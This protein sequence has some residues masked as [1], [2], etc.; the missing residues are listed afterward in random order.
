[1]CMK[2]EIEGFSVHGGEM[3]GSIAF[4]DRTLEE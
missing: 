3:R 2:G 1:M 4:L